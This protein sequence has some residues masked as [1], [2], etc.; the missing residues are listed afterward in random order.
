MPQGHARAISE[1]HVRGVKTNIPFVTNILHPPH[2]PGRQVPHQVHRRDARALRDRRTAGTGPPRCSS[3]SPRSR[4][5]TPPPSA[6]SYDIPRFPPV[7][8]T[9]RP[10]GLKQLLDQKGPEAVQGLGAGP[11]EAAH[12]R[13]HHAGRPPVPA[14]HPGA[15][16]GHAEGR[17][18][19]RRD[20]D[21]LLLPGDV[22]RRHLRRGLPLPP[23]VP[24]GAAGPAAGE[25]PQHPLPDAAAGRQRRGLHQLPRQP[26]PGLCPG[27]R[28]SPA[29]TCS[30]SSTP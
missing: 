16:P 1:E 29:S 14:V 20:P 2:L 12:H 18:R 4:W 24:L 17:R 7:T 5:T 9:P 27:G 15:H 22:G 23:R 10:T 30:A 26:D 6:S 11:E 25:D 19:H 3:T 28:T 8:E 13:H 21:R